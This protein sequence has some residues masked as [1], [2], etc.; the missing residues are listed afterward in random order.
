VVNEADPRESKG[1]PSDLK[2]G[3]VPVESI[4]AGLEKVLCSRHFLASEGRSRFLRFVVEQALQNRLDHLKEYVIGV[5]VFGRGESFDP[6]ADSIVRVEAR[7]IRAKLE[8]YYEMEG[9]DDPVR[10]DLPKGRYAPTFRERASAGKETARP[11]RRQRIPVWYG[12]GAALL[13]CGAGVAYWRHA[14][15]PPIRGVDSIAVLPFTNLSQEVETQYFSDGLTAELIA[16]LMKRGRPRVVGSTSVFQYKG[17][18]QDI[19]RTG[20]ELGAQAI[21]EG[22]VRKSGS[23]LRINAGLVE[24][25][26]GLHLWSQ[27]YDREWKDV[28]AVQEEI[29]R[30][31]AAALRVELER[32]SQEHPNTCSDNLEAYDLYLR[33]IHAEIRRGAED[34]ARSLD[35]L[36]RAAALNPN[37]AS[38]Y[39]HLGG[40]YLLHGFY[41]IKAPGEV[42]PKAREAARKAIAMDETLPLGHAALGA[43]LALYD[44]DWSSAEREF[45]R[46]LEINPESTQARQW[47]SNFVLAPQRRFDEALLEI[48][49]A[50]WRD[51]TSPALG[52]TEAA[53]LYFAGQYDLSIPQARR[54]IE[55]QPDFWLSYLYLAW[56]FQRKGMFPEAGEAIAQAVSRAEGNLL[57]KLELAVLDA[58]RGR[59]DSARG[60]L[61]ELET[62]ARSSYVPAVVFAHIY[63]VLGEKEEAFRWLHRARDERS[64]ML[65]FAALAHDFDNI[66]DDPRFGAVLREIGIV[67]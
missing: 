5:E 51:P 21:V 38:V 24:V 18:A 10:I 15:R 66:S 48:R 23:R 28:L 59:K 37:C 52:A 3:A 26:S 56:S 36:S 46:A 31:I 11:V 55:R 40:S 17:K 20:A 65:V 12:A 29:A 61:R 25:S 22:S 9:R 41:G 53:I 47:Y 39:A 34:L 43:T 33:G 67:H 50:K 16:A 62:K 57:P 4:R 13:L 44:W 14:N 2:A 27:T 30:D 19:R 42:M 63:S 32:T 7:K 64:P 58:M 35:Y 8:E 45:R 49:E 1:F 6:K 60:I 54:T